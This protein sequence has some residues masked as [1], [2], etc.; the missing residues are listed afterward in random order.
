MNDEY[1]NTE[2][3]AKFIGV[4]KSLVEKWRNKG[5]LMPDVVGHGK[6]GHSNVY[7]YSKEHVMQLASVYLNNDAHAN[8]S[9]R[10]FDAHST[11]TG[12]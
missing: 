1:M 4:S 2:E 5:W 11:R 10:Q 3:L 12:R 9:R 6:N 8:R 7:Y